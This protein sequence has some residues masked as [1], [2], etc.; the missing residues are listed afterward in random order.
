[1]G[2]ANFFVYLCDSVMSLLLF[3]SKR[4]L[5]FLYMFLWFVLK[6]LKNPGELRQSKILQVPLKSEVLQMTGF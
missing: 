3:D 5:L 4:E 6:W 2:A 1:M